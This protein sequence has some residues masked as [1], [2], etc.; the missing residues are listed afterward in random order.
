MSGQRVDLLTVDHA[1]RP[2]LKADARRQLDQAFFRSS[3]EGFFA[4]HTIFPSLLFRR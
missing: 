4:L 1:N 3:G 2:Q